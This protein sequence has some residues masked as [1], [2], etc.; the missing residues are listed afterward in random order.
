MLHRAIKLARENTTDLQKMGAVIVKRKRVLGEGQNSRKTHPLQRRF[1]NHDLKTA[2][3]AEIAAIVDALRNH[4]IEELRGSEIFVAR[5]M[6]NGSTG[7]AKPCTSCQK[8]LDEYG[9]SA[10]YWTEYED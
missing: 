7:K 1:S 9:I 4:E 2:I 6:K 3:H 10:V 8:A 5:I